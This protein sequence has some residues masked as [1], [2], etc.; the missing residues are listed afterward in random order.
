MTDDKEELKPLAGRRVVCE[1]VLIPDDGWYWIPVCDLIGPPGEEYE[2][3]LN[4]RDAFRDGFEKAEA[5]IKELEKI[6]DEGMP[7]IGIINAEQLKRIKEL[8]AKYDRL[9]K[10]SNERRLCDMQHEKMYMDARE[11]IKELEADLITLAK[12]ASDEW[13]TEKKDEADWTRI[14]QKVELLEVRK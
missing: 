2:R 9:W 10:E 4:D 5:R 6:I 3:L 11:R 1:W 7:R 12:L 14:M 13:V 8:E